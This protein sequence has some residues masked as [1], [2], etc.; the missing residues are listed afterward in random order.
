MGAMA[1]KIYN[2][3]EIAVLVAIVF[4]GSFMENSA[5]T[6]GTNTTDTNTT[7]MSTAILINVDQSG[8]GD[9]KKIQDAIDA[10]PSKNSE[11]YFIWIK[12]GTYRSVCLCGCTIFM[13]VNWFV[14]IYVLTGLLLSYACTVKQ[15]KTSSACG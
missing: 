13:M 14:Y 2:G 1:M 9:F 12:P 15:G 3:Y 8:N 10:V 7:D 5:T 4:L 11:L 6:T